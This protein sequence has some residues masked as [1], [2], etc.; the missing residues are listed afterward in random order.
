MAGPGL[1]MR[2]QR[3]NNMQ[4]Q[5]PQKAAG[6]SQPEQRAQKCWPEL[7]LSKVYS[8]KTHEAESILCVA[9]GGMLTLGNH[10]HGN[11]NTVSAV[12]EY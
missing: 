2:T 4:N 8:I 10:F 3:D 9:S 7:G 1:A 5:H 11:H 6:A 12:I